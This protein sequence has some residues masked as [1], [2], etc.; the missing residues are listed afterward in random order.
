MLLTDLP[1]ALPLLKLNVENNRSNW[2]NS[3]GN[4]EV[5]P[6]NWGENTK[7]NFVP[8]L[9][10]L[11]DCVYYKKV[12]QWDFVCEIELYSEF[13]VD[14]LLSTDFKGSSNT[15]DQNFSKP[16]GEG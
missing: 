15:T 9:I 8:D 7:I 6:L 12:N 13:L 16:R 1:E 4:A 10:L 3:R 5:V 11:A 14:R 2:Q